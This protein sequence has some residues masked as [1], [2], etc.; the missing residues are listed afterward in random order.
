MQILKYVQSVIST[1]TLNNI[2]KTMKSKS[3]LLSL[4]DDHL[5]LNDDEHDPIY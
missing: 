2:L 3:I 5:D 1:N 4:V